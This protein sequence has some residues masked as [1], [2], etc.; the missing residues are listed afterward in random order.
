MRVFAASILLM[1]ALA[2][3]ARVPLQSLERTT[4]SGSDYIRV[5]D[6]A[7]AAGFDM[8]WEK[9]AGTILLTSPA[10]RM[11]MTIDSR[12]ADICGVNIWFSLPVVNRNGVPMFSV[13]DAETT[14][15]PILFP[16]R[17]T[18][19][20][21][22][23]CIDPGHGGKDTGYVQ[24]GNYE[25]K[26]SLL[27]A[28]DVADLLKRAGLQVLLTRNTDD[29]VDLSN[30][31]QIAKRQGADVFVSLHYNAAPERDVRGL[32]V[33]C[34]SPAWMNSSSDGGGRGRNPPE[35]GNAHDP[36]NALLAYEMVKSITSGVPVADRG[37]KRSRFEVLRD[38]AMPAILIEGGF[39]SNSADS[40]NIYDAGFRKKMAQAIVDGILAYKRMI[41]R[42]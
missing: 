3:Y 4:V 37:M 39:M 17:S 12:R 38:A 11:D 24:G 34:L 7:D 19:H 32:E 14:V 36:Q 6:W 8:K 31:S 42:F 41:E 1:A 2:A 29:F 10:C 26:Y 35:T 33:Y 5:D 9:K 20:L 21:T 22:T 15:E 13:V 23:I 16:R 28:H 30:R 40:K 18:N 25:K 27:L